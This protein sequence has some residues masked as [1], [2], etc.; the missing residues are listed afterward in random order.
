MFIGK[1][2]LFIKIRTKFLLFISE[3]FLFFE[4]ENKETK[5]R[6]FFLKEI[7]FKIGCD[8]IIDKNI[9][10]Y[11]P[12]TI[13]I[14]NHIL[15][16]ENCYLDHDI[17]IEDN[18]TISKDV[19]ILTAGHNP[20]T[21]EYVMMPVKI[22]NNVWIGAKAIILPGVTVGENSCVAAGSVVSKNVNANML[23]GGVPAREIRSID[24]KSFTDIQ[25]Y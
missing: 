14:G 1:R 23:V 2:K 3:F 5:I 15:I 21:M 19:I 22:C 16:R 25:F 11:E 24:K 13:I 6:N 9:S 8:V 17:I 18:V 12:K 7:G 10:F 4:N 20:E